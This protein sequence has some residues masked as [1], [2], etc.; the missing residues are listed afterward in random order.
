MTADIIKRDITEAQQRAAMT[1]GQVVFFEV[2]FDTDSIEAP[3]AFDLLHGFDP[4]EYRQNL[5][6][7]F[8]RVHP[9]DRKQTADLFSDLRNS[10]NA[11]EGCINYRIVW[12]DESVRWLTARMEVVRG[13]EG[14]ASKL[15]GVLI[16]VTDQ[17]AIEAELREA[18]DQRDLLIAEV[19]HRVKNSLQLVTS[20]LAMEVRSSKSEDARRSLEAAR[21]RIQ[22]IGTI[23]A[24]LYEDG[25]VT[26]VQM[27]RY[28]HRFCEHL[29]VSVGADARHIACEV[30]ADA[31]RLPTNKAITLSLVVNELVTNAVKHA[32]DEGEPGKISISLKKT[33]F[34]RIVLIVSDNGKSDGDATP[35]DRKGLGT[36]LITGSVAQ[37]GGTMEQTRGGNGWRTKIE[38]SV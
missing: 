8:E 14:H 7:Y 10:P 31:V 38:F 34:D 28:L 23:H 18:L 16:D 6:A 17:H 37:L 21:A 13:A 29:A 15:S 24:S 26:S 32:F 33:G 27:D 2:E 9:E 22:A 19:N 11:T 1:G 30:D 12:P 3:A 36:R 5:S 25:D 35:P 4:G 20:I